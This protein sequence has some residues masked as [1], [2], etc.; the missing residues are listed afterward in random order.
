M[1]MKNN[2][3]ITA[4]AVFSLG[5]SVAPVGQA[6]A[7]TFAS[8]RHEVDP[9]IGRANPVAGR[10]RRRSA[11]PMVIRSIHSK[12]HADNVRTSR[13]AS[14]L[15]INVLSNDD[16]HE[17]RIVNINMR[18]AVGGR[19]SVKN[20]MVVYKLP[21]RFVGKDSFWYTVEDVT[22]H[23]YSAKVIVCICDK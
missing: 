8:E 21:E 1:K 14:K 2:K 5:L 12:A 7:G 22:G 13:Q 18:S 9:V 19:V 15:R 11:R 4:L 20:G 23:R 10:N 6:N 16:G 17:L 3:I